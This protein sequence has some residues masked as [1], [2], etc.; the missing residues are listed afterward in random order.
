MAV[1]SLAPSVPCSSISADVAGTSHDDK[2]AGSNGI[3]HPS[4]L[5]KKGP[6]LTENLS[7]IQT[8]LTSAIDELEAVRKRYEE[9]SSKTNGRRGKLCTKCHM[10]GHNK[11]RCLNPLCE[12]MNSCGAS[13]RHPESKNEIVELQRL[14]KDLQKKEAK[15]S[16]ELRSFK[17]AKERSVN[18][19]FAV[20]RPR[21]RKQNKGCFVD[22]FALDKD[23]KK[24]F[25]NKVPVDTSQ[26]WQMPFLIE[27]HRRALPSLNGT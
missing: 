14:I 12:D 22:R 27:W 4:Y 8:Q 6:E 16:E 26:D 18:S 9:A 24:I 15:A 10:P 20:M 2:S 25:N 11:A 1:G 23:L 3:G 5:E 19:F 13:E 21:L 7:F 17:L